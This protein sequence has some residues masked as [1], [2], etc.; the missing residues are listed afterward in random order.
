MD[1]LD[2]SAMDN[3][4]G[5][6]LPGQVG[7]TDVVV[8]ILRGE[9]DTSFGGIVQSIVT[10]LF[11]QL[12]VFMGLLREMVLII[13]LGAVLTVLSISLKSKSTSDLGFYIIYIIVVS[14][15]L[16][17]FIT[18]VGVMQEFSAGLARI[19]E[20]A[21]PL[22]ASLLLV[23]GNITSAAI[24]NPLAML[25]AGTMQIVLRD[26]I[27]PALI[28][29]AILEIVNH[30]TERE[31]VSKLAE[32]LRKLIKYALFTLAGLFMGLLTLHR[33]SAP[34]LD[35]AALRTARAAS[36][37]IPVVGQA[38][39]GAVDLA[40][41]WADTVKSSV[42]TG[43]IIVII[44]MMMPIL[45]KAVAFV[46]A[47]KLTAAIVEPICDKRIVKAI[48][49]AGSLASLVLAACALAMVSFLFMVMLMISL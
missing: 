19:V 23:S 43:V 10:P 29:T 22:M 5:F 2:M 34:I 45:I 6:G 48:N 37:A 21:V 16:S 42:L 46:F 30:M 39:S 20:A 4:A 3:I 14:I 33:L 49:A 26:I 8:Q 32:L 35:N 7:F 13:I 28:V 38:L 31:L 40:V 25:A 27:A 1:N 24:M 36:G 44:V 47:Y 9:L 11:S 41:L 17:S 12:S 18:A 15:L